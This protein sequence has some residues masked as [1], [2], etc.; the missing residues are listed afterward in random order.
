MIFKE[1]GLEKS[2]LR[3]ELWQTLSFRSNGGND[4]HRRLSHEEGS[5]WGMHVCLWQIHFDIWQNQCN[6]VKLKNK[7]ELKNKLIN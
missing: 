1:K 7:I 4:H 3:T 5:G 6:I 2:G